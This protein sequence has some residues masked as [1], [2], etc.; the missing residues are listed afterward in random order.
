[1][2]SRIGRT[3]RQDQSQPTR[4]TE[5]FM[6][7]ITKTSLR[8]LLGAAV[9]AAVALSNAT[10]A[11]AFAYGGGGGAGPSLQFFGV[12]GMAV[13]AFARLNVAVIGPSQDD[14][15]PR[16]CPVRLA[17]FSPDGTELMPAEFLVPE[18]ESR[19]LEFRRPPTAE[20]TL[21]VRAVVE[22]DPPSEAQPPDSEVPPCTVLST[23]EI[24]DGLT[25]LTVVLLPPAVQIDPTKK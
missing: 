24:V 5:D 7:T 3:A 10:P 23:L 1:M 6:N 9:L 18:G 11:S 4:T 14:P 15:V 20:G 22:S 21:L 19:S 2:P 13:D 16:L 8:A 17:F 25:G 12:T